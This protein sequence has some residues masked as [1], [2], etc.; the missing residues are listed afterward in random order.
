MSS[1]YLIAVGSNR[2]HHVFGRPRD[3]VRTAMEELAALGTV[4]RRSDVIST[5]P[6]GPARR[7]FANAACV[8]TSEYDPQSLLAGLKHVEREFGRRD[9]Q[10]WGDRVLD[11]D[12]VL[13]SGG[14]FASRGLTIPHAEFRNRDFVLSPACQIAP[15]WRDPVTGLHIRHLLARV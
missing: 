2:R 5:D 3:V 4:A 7:R 12:I 9:G 14:S 6:I 11:L 15:D 10:R 1:S 13:W 8:L